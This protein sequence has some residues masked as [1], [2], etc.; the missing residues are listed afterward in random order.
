M[1]HA[2]VSRIASY[3]NLGDGDK[4]IEDDESD[5]DFK[6]YTCVEKIWRQ[7]DDNADSPMSECKLFSLYRPSLLIGSFSS[8]HPREGSGN[9][10][11]R[12]T[13]ILL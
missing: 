11:A 12:S 1:L 5:I 2:L 4:Q 3:E 9:R 8:L 6:E 13:Q 7:W 10:S